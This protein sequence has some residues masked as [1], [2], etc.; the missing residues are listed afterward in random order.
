MKSVLRAA[1]FV[2]P[3]LWTAAA[4][5]QFDQP[6]DRRA[7]LDFL[8]NEQATPVVLVNHTE[9]DDIY[10]LLIMEIAAQE[11]KI[12]MA[13]ETAMDLARERKI[14]RLAKRAMHLYL[15]ASQPRE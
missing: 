3:L 4:H 2:A 15:A 8:S 6:A 11:G 10:R 13:A 7:M 12:D 5:A 9:A 14:P 1:V